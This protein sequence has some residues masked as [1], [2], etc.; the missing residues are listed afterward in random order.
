MCFVVCKTSSELERVILTTLYF[1]GAENT[2]SWRAGKW[3]L[4]HAFPL[5]VSMGAL[6]SSPTALMA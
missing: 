2:D 4:Q 1:V 3:E 5:D 6:S